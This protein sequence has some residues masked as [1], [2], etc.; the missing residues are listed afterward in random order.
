MGGGAEGE[1]RLALTCRLRLQLGAVVLRA[2][3]LDLDQGTHDA[4]PV[5]REMAGSQ[6]LEAA[7]TLISTTVVSMTL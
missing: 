3:D 1:E 2:A 4:T 7:N 5:L 6:H